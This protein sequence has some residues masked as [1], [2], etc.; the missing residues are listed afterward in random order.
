MASIDFTGIYSWQT[1]PRP[2]LSIKS[3]G[4][5][6]LISWTVPSM[7]FLLQQNS[8]VSSNGWTDVNVDPVMTNFE[9]QVTIPR[10]AGTTFYRLVSRQ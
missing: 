9:N 6:I 1:I 5:D 2:V 4:E 7:T 3:L 8:D 10:P